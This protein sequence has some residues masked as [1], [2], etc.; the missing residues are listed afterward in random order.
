MF[1]IQN[2]DRSLSSVPS[3]VTNSASLF[4]GQA[5]MVSKERLIEGTIEQ[6]NWQRQQD[7]VGEF[8]SGSTHREDDRGRLG[9]TVERLVQ[10]ALPLQAKGFFT[11]EQ[12]WK[13]HITK[14]TDTEFEARMEDLTKPGTFEIGEFEIRDVSPGDR[15]LLSIGAV[16]Y[17]SI[18]RSFNGNQVEKNA[19]MRFQRLTSWSQEEFDVATD[20][21]SELYEFFNNDGDI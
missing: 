5:Y 17:W 4:Q 19:L 8:M 18:G 2:T 16:F 20:K 14:L 21:G 6:F 7:N 13:G 12:R 1:N 9:E 3:K 15:E 10:A 11:S